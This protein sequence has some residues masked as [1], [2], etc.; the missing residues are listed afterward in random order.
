MKK[1][2]LPLL[3]GLIG[4]LLVTANFAYA[5][6][7]DYAEEDLT[8]ARTIDLCLEYKEA[9]DDRKSALFKE[10]DRRGMVSYRD[11]EGFKSG[12]IYPGTSVCGMY[13][14]KGDP[15]TE[16]A[17]QLRPLTFKTVHVYPE[18]YYVSQ[19]GIVMRVL[20]RKE[21]IL[22]PNLIE[23]LPDVAHPPVLHNR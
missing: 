22:P 18:N 12:N 17:R 19:S 20:E 11:F 21:G 23:K 14:I 7:A 6:Y 5:D 13:M 15:I 9:S 1:I 10:I 8:K 3:I 2:L 4:A 16:Q